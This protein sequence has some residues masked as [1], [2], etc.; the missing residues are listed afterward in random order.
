MRY[1]LVF[2]F[3]DFVQLSPSSSLGNGGRGGD[4]SSGLIAAVAGLTGGSSETPTKSGRPRFVKRKK[5]VKR[6]K[7]VDL[8]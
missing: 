2:L 1:A 7:W 5:V 8:D 4:A 3:F 6:G